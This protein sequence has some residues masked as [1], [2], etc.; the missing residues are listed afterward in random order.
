MKKSDAVRARANIPCPSGRLVMDTT[1]ALPHVL[2]SMQVAV[3]KLDDDD[4][5]PWSKTGLRG[6][7]LTILYY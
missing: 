6:F 1:V 3:S 4:R 2:S 5:R 7:T